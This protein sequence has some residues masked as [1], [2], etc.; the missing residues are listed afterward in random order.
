LLSLAARPH[1]RLLALGAD[2]GD[3]HGAKFPTHDLD[4][5]VQRCNLPELWRDGHQEQ[6]TT[7]GIIRNDTTNRKL[8]FEQVTAWQ[9]LV[10]AGKKRLDGL[11]IALK[12]KFSEFGAV[13]IGGQEVIDQ[14]LGR[15]AVSGDV[16]RFSSRQCRL[17][18]R[19]GRWRHQH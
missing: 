2:G 8:S 14:H 1:G 11:R 9:L 18:A 13:L 4:Q 12:G 17:L 10:D 19:G 5:D 6:W 16:R 3:V 7:D 15:C